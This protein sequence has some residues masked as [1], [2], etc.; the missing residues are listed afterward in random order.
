MSDDLNSLKCKYAEDALV[1]LLR[2]I[3]PEMRKST[4]EAAIE[5]LAKQEARQAKAIEALSDED[6]AKI[7]ETWS[8]A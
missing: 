8:G 6:L 4:I 2:E 3:P 1:A 5:R 7:T